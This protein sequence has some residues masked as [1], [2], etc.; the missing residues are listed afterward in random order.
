[1]GEALGGWQLAGIYTVHTGTP[2]TFYD[3]S[4][5]TSGY[6]IAR[7]TPASA[8]S[9]KTFKSISQRGGRGR[10]ELVRDRN[11]A[12]GKFLEQSGSG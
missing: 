1:M 10:R 7:Y 11:S 8:L 3:S 12:G 9:K 6:N 2:F 5:N 4:N